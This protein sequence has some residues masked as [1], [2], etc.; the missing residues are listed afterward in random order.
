MFVFLSS[1]AQNKF[2]F[3]RPFVCAVAGV[4][5]CNNGENK[6]AGNKGL[7]L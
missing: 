5:F 2:V 4:F 7:L 6:T 3:H 1:P